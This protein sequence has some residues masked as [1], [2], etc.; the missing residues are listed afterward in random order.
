[1]RVKSTRKIPGNLRNERGVVLIAVLMFIAMI[2]PVTLLILDSVRIESLLPVNEAYMRTAG[3][4]ADKGFQDALAAIMADQD[5]IIVDSSRDITDTAQQYFYSRNSQSRSGEHD[6]DYLAEMWARHPDNDTMF[7]VERSLENIDNPENPDAG[8]DEEVHSIPTRWQLMNVPFGMDDFGEYYDDGG[9]FPRLLQPFEYV[10]EN[11]PANPTDAYAPVYYIDPSEMSMLNLQHE[12]TSPSKYSADLL[13]AKYWSVSPA[14]PN[15][16]GSVASLDHAFEYEPRPASYFR[17]TS[18]TP[19]RG[20][21]GVGLPNTE[22]P[23]NFGF[24]QEDANAV[25]RFVYDGLYDFNNN[26]N[27]YPNFLPLQQAVSD[28]TWANPYFGSTGAST[29]LTASFTSSNKEYKPSPGTMTRYQLGAEEDDAIPGWHE[30][31]VSDESGRFPI[32]SLLNIIFASDNIDYDDLTEP[33]TERD[34][35]DNADAL[36]VINDATHPNH[37]GFLLARDILTSLLM[38]DGDMARMADAWDANLFATY[39]NR[40]D[41]IIRQMLTRRQQLDLTSDF[42]RNGQTDDDSFGEIYQFPEMTGNQTTSVDLDGSGRMGDAQDLWDGSWRVYANPKDILTNFMGTSPGVN[43]LTPKNFATLNQRVTVYS[44]DTEHTADP[45]H[46]RT[47]VGSPTVPDVRLNF[48]HM[49]ETDDVSTP[50]IDESKLYD[51]LKTDLIGSQRVKSILNWRDGLVDLNGDGDLND[52]FIEQPVSDERYDPGSNAYATLGDAPVSTITYR[53]RNHPNFQDPSLPEEYIDPDMLNIRNLG[54]LISVPMSFNDTIIAYSRAAD[55]TSAPTLVI[56]TLNNADPDGI[57]RSENDRLYPDFSSSGTELAYDQDAAEVFTND[58]LLTNENSINTSREHPSWGPGDATICYYN[59]DDII[60][61]DFASD[62]ETT[63]VTGANMP[64]DITDTTTLANFWGNWPTN[65]VGDARFEMGSPDI[66]PSPGFDEIAFTQVG[67]SST[68]NEFL[69]P[70]VAYNIVSVK[71]DGTSQDLITDNPIGTYDYAPDFSPDGTTIAFTRTS[72]DPMGFGLPLPINDLGLTNLYEVNRDGSNASPVF[73]W[74]QFPVASADPD[75]GYITINGTTLTI[76]QP[77]FPAY[78]PDGNQIIFMDIPIVI[79]IDFLGPPPWDYTVQASEAEIYRVDAGVVLGLWQNEVT[80]V[81]SPHTSGIYEIFPDWGVG[82]VRLAYQD[83][84]DYGSI[85]GHAVD[86]TNARLATTD[87]VTGHFTETDRE[88]IAM[89]IG[90]ASLALRMSLGFGTEDQNWRLKDLPSVPEQTVDV[91]EVLGDIVSFRDPF[92]R[93]D[94][95][96]DNP[97][98]LNQTI[99]PPIQAYAG[100]ININTATRPV[101]RSVFLNMFQGPI[102]DIDSSG[103]VSGPEPRYQSGMAGVYINLLSNATT[104][105]QRFMAMMIA[106]KYANQVCEYRKWVYNNQGHLGITDETVPSNLPLYET[107]Y[108]NASILVSHYGNFR[109]N[110]FYPLIDTDGD[111]TNNPDITSFAPDPPFRSTADL[112]R[113]MLYDNDA[114]PEDWTYE[115][116]GSAAGPDDTDLPRTLDVDGNPVGSLDA[117]EVFGPIYNAD[118]ERQCTHPDDGGHLAGGVMY[119]FPTRPDNNPDTA[120]NPFYNDFYEAQS[121]RLFSADDF[122]RIAPWLTTRTYDYRIESRGVMRVASGAAR[123]DIQRDKIWIITTNT[124]AF[125]GMRLNTSNVL[126]DGLDM[127]FLGQNRGADNYFVMYYEETPQSGLALTR[128]SFLPD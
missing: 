22:L 26:I 92:V 103:E 14:D 71:T 39:Q 99:V 57:A 119:G 62:S 80:P 44:M 123:T 34:Y 114:F 13:T 72:Y 7:L 50:Y 29:L 30:A 93:Y 32:N 36:D 82:N 75:D 115:G 74:Q 27:Q 106:D 10:G 46:L 41:W 126:T 31:I 70:N 100:R 109:A 87:T 3:D 88:N 63:A 6:L 83:D 61:Y 122:K 102:A 15:F 77:M 20:I 94:A 101:L 73:D 78:S 66:S 37:G 97:D 90:E 18:G 107:A 81:T 23:T 95:R 121:F 17:N 108:Q 19:S 55:S 104:N 24:I 67:S 56:K 2:L 52:E 128:G 59:T 49:A 48:Q 96:F 42:N 85:R 60:L 9:D 117:L 45:E 116:I 28:S 53:E 5:N 65:L 47:G 12:G 33:A 86:L 89:D 40:A 124:E 91:L 38:E 68:G 98:P 76:H 64:P 84:T 35:F 79:N 112:F 118:D 69:D 111:T 110:P 105:D 113:V 11:V 8:P 54:E 58:L 120:V 4:E 21:A 43:A 16:Y 51:I 1:M 25:D 125:Y 127:S